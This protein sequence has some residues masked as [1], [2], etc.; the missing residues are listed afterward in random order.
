ML[1]TLNDMSIPAA[2][3]AVT[4]LVGDRRRADAPSWSSCQQLAD[5]HMSVG[6]IQSTHSALADLATGR[7]EVSCATQI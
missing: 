4:S 5:Q 7:R 2:F 3:F 6:A 1:P